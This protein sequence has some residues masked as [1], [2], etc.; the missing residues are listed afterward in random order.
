[1]NLVSSTNALIGWMAV[2]S[3]I[4]YLILFAGSFFET[5]IFSSFFI[6]GEIFFLAGAILA[7]THAVSI[8]LVVP[9]LYG[10]AILG[11]TA[12][13]YCGHRLGASIF[14]EHR[15]LFSIANYNRG[16][17]FFE[18]HGNKA[19]FLARISGPISWVMPF[20][21]GAYK[22]PYRSFLIYN[23]AGVII[24]VGQFIVLGYFFGLAF[25]K[26]FNYIQDIFK[27][28]AVV[29]TVIGVVYFVRKRFG[30]KSS[31]P[32]SAEDII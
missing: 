16:L 23:I 22:V 31:A 5:F 24:G 21:A 9:I 20:M 28:L 17:R 11:D 4:T 18:K 19:V 32:E 10:G 8:W 29:A 27:V 7:S 12:S 2:H 30:P 26:M 3:H 1:M 6:Y 25:L 15:K 13:Y 14:K